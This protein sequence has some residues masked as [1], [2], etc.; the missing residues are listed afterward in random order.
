MNIAASGGLRKRENERAQAILA[1]IGD[2][3]VHETSQLPG[4]NEPKAESIGLPFSFGIIAI[5]LEDVIG[6]VES[7]SRAIIVNGNLDGVER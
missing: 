5:R 2:V 7:D 6:I 1:L 4:D 3:A